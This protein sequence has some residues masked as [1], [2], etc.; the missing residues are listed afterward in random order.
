M[1][2]FPRLTNM[3]NPESSSTKPHAILLDH[4]PFCAHEFYIN[5]VLILALEKSTRVPWCI[6]TIISWEVFFSLQMVSFRHLD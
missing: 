3:L 5:N 4:H 1:L 2:D 6:C